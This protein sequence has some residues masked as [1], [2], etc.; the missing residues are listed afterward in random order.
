MEEHGL[1][2]AETGVR[3]PSLAPRV[4]QAPHARCVFEPCEAQAGIEGYF[5]NMNCFM[6]SKTRAPKE[7]SGFE[8]RR[9]GTRPDDG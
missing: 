7:E 1:P 9:C 5:E 8:S 4:E 3:F 2:K 6:F